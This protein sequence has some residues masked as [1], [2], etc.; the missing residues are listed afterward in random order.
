MLTAL[1]ATINDS[2]NYILSGFTPPQVV[3]ILYT[4]HLLVNTGGT[5]VT[6]QFLDTIDYHRKE[7]TVVKCAPEQF[8]FLHS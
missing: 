5:L 6:K 4:F 3:P 2:N 1:S 8:A 7:T